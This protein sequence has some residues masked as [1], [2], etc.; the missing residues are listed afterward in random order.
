MSVADTS[1]LKNVSDIR[2]YPTDVLTAWA[3]LKFPNV[4][5]SFNN[6]YFLSR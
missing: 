4:G 6:I 3:K 5:Y 1:G 2:I